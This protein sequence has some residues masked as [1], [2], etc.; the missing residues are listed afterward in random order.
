M[1]LPTGSE[2]SWGTTQVQTIRETRGSKS[3]H[4]T[5]RTDNYREAKAESEM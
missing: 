4:K 5:D 1:W 3:E 2:Y